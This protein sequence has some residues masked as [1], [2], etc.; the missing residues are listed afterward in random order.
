LETYLELSVR[1]GFLQADECAR[2]MN[3]CDSVGRMLS[4]PYRA[5]KRKIEIADVK[6]PRRTL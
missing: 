2:I 1:L 6:L 3:L 4:G 5:L